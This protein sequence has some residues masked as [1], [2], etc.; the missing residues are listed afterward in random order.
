MVSIGEFH[1]AKSPHSSQ[2]P[3]PNLEGPT[4]GTLDDPCWPPPKSFVGA[5][6]SGNIFVWVK[7]P[8]HSWDLWMFIPFIPPKCYTNRFS[9]IPIWYIVIS[10]HIA[11]YPWSAPPKSTSEDLCPSERRCA[12]DP[13]GPRRASHPGRFWAGKAETP[14]FS[15]MFHIYIY[16]YMQIYAC[17]PA[18]L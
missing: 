18:S 6:K 8:C 14:G 13:G 7:N 3:S 5:W 1:M 12:N 9:Y 2:R 10:L 16:A 4:L 11:G 15:R 17:A